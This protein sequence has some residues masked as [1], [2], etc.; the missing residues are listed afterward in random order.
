MTVPFL[1]AYWQA[2]LTTAIIMSIAAVGLQVT[3]S[4]GQFSVMHSALMGVAGYV[5][6]VLAADHR[7]WPMIVSLVAGMIV[8]GAMGAAASLLLLRL[9]G[10]FLGIATLAIAQGMSIIAST[11][12]PGHAAGFVGAPLRTTLPIAILCLLMV[13]FV[14]SRLRSSRA[15]MSQLAAGADDVAA[16]SLGI[17]VT[18][19]K[20]WG[21]AAGGAITGLAGAL[22]VQY[23][24]LVTPADLGIGPALNLLIY[25]VLG[26][27][28]TPWG[29]VLGATGMITMLE[30]LRVAD[31]DRYWVLGLVLAVVV[32][33]RPRGLLT[34]VPVGH[35]MPLMQIFRRLSRSIRAARP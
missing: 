18:A 35:H 10:L 34:R 13:M 8:S 30:A 22:N 15:G 6:G 19:S 28:S 3:M 17:S 21:F 4:S 23:L 12:F 9:G 20:V 32:L 11:T 25:V 31:L 14:L 2:V 29:A 33:V 16:S 26:G 7:E 27:M 24:G 1:D 5:G